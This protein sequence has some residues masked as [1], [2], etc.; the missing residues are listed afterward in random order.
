MKE[1]NLLASVAL[2]SELYNNENYSNVGDILGEFIKAVIVTEKSWTVTTTKLNILLEKTFDFK[3]PESVIK[4]TLKNRLKDYYS[5]TSNGEYAFYTSKLTD[6]DEFDDKFKTLILDQNQIISALHD[7]IKTKNVHN[8][9]DNQELLENLNNYLF[10]N[11]RNDKYYRYISAFVIKYKD[12]LTYMNTLNLMREGLILYQGIKYTDNIN[13]SGKWNNELTIYLSTEHLFNAIGYNG[14]V[15][16]QIFKDFYD[17]VSEINASNKSKSS[18]KLI[19][20]RY[21]EETKDEIDQFFQTA[22]YI[23]KGT[24]RLDS[25]KPA[26]V[27]IVDGCKQPIDIKNKKIFFERKLKE[28]DILLQEFNHSPYKYKDYVVDDENVLQ[29][30]KREAEIRG[31]RF[32]ENACR[33]FF[34]I[35]TKINYYRGG[36]SRTNFERIDRIF[37]TA[38]RFALYLAH[39]TK[40]KFNE[41]DIPFA[42]DIDYIISKFWFKL[43]KGFGTSISLPKSLDVVTKAQIVLSS[44]VNQFVSLGYQKLQK[45]FKDGLLTEEEARE[46]SY[47]LRLKPNKPEEFVESNIDI[48]LDFLVNDNWFEDTQREKQ[49]KEAKFEETVKKNREL[50]LEIE[51]IREKENQEKLKIEREKYEIE[52]QQFL[53]EEWKIY[54]KN[55]NENFRYWLG[56]E[57]VTALPIILG[58]T[59]RINKKT[60]EW[61]LEHGQNYI[62]EVVLTFIFIFEVTGRS[63]LFKKDKIS[64]GWEWVKIRLSR[65][66]FAENKQQVIDELTQRFDSD[67]F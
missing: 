64:D 62:Y 12:N 52:K 15:Y 25:S 57:F 21:F 67:K 40:V 58:F 28:K 4:T 42:K 26:M 29:M 46:K 38:D 7:Y 59:L 22:E 20:L 17:L 45:D 48:S 36:E 55:R 18:D 41:D 24:A 6:F 37:I 49:L 47:E 60:N 32:D 2:F 44:Q 56:V 9:I 11:G 53:I 3:I 30:I 27:I 34:K 63:Y 54:K 66:K 51:K 14:L 16:E 33:K 50:E 8:E 43:K 13:E 5:R 19:K 61:L 65:S 35:F 1:N 39:N 10:D 23:L 31:R